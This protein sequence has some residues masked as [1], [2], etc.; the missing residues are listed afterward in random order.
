MALSGL[1][2]GFIIGAIVLVIAIVIVIIIVVLRVRA[3]ANRLIEPVQAVANTTCNQNS[4]CTSRACNTARNICVDCLDDTFCGDDLP[5]CRLDTQQCKECLETTDCQVGQT[6]IEGDCCDPTDPTIDS[7]VYTPGLDPTLTIEY[8]M[9]QKRIPSNK[10]RVVIVDPDTDI[11]FG[12]SECF[13]TPITDCEINTGMPCDEPCTEFSSVDNNIVL[14]ESVMGFKFHTG[15]PYRIIIQIFY[16]CGGQDFI[17]NPITL[18]YTIPTCLDT[19]ATGIL[20][21]SEV[22]PP[23]EM[24][25]VVG[26][27]IFTPNSDPIETYTLLFNTIPDLHPSF[28]FHLEAT[29]ELGPIAPFDRQ[30]IRLSELPPPDTYYVRIIRNGTGELCD[31][32]PLIIEASFST[33]IGV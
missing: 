29:A 28:A 19:L 5:F 20:A 17:T 31:S 26:I 22:I 21:I 18:D 8:T 9:F 12:M 15:Y 14:R 4:D 10:V 33:V 24:D 3:A 27:T 13:T 25:S 30:I 7:V 2:I 32:S 1:A 16:G 11:P 23:G 6:C